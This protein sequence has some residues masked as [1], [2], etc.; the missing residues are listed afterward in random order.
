MGEP[1]DVTGMH[2]PIWRE[3]SEPRDGLEPVPSW[4]TAIFWGFLFWGGFY[5]AWYSAEFRPHV[6]DGED[7]QRRRSR[8]RKFWMPATVIA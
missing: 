3:Q 5:V 1:F 6:Y 2:T 4:I 8:R 7:E